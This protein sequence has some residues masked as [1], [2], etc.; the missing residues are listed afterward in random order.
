LIDKI[1]HDG[2]EDFKLMNGGFLFKKNNIIYYKSSNSNEF[3]IL[4][5]PKNLIKQFFAMNQTLYIYDGEFLNHYQLKK[6]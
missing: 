6:D 5:F 3:H 1:K 2:F 4:E